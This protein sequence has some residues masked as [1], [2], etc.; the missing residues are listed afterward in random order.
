MIEKRLSTGDRL[1]STVTEQAHAKI[2]LTLEVLGKRADGYHNLV[3][4]MTTI[5]LHD[6]VTAQESDRI[7]LKDDGGIPPERNLVMTAANALLDAVGTSCGA[8]I[9]L[10]KRIPEAAGLGG[11]SADAAA[12]LRAL[13]RLWGL[14][15][16]LAELAEI[17]ARVGSDVPFLVHE[18]TALVQGRGED[19]TPLPPPAIDRV[20][21]LSPGIHVGNKT[22]TLFS[23][24]GPNRY[25]RGAL[26]HKLAA[27]IRAGH[28][29][30]PEFFFNAFQDL[31]PE[32]FE[33]W[34]TYH[35]A[36]VGLGA[37]EVVLS[38]AGPSMF[39]VPPVKEIG[40]TWQL[41][42]E[43]TRGWR[44]FLTEPFTPARAG[45]DV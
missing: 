5:G 39:C 17:G 8:L 25:T 7:E 2:N 33:G 4:V 14:G 23:L 31:A 6:V 24:I 1:S 43:R 45:E 28:D 26:S 30:P 42:L 13:N 9:S 29:S 22:Q 34:D 21:V 15:L 37:R 11:G 44:A 19:I 41:L 16:S 38:G 27:R 40:T 32:V 20:L 35:D 18:G 10:E 12:T 36:L 3:T